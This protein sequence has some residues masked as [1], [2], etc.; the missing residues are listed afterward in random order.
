MTDDIYYEIPTK[1]GINADEIIR[2]YSKSNWG[3]YASFNA[4]ELPDEYLKADSF[5]EWLSNK[6]EMQLILFYYPPYYV[7][8]WHLDLR[9]GSTLNL[10]LT[11]DGNSHCIF[12]N[13]LNHTKKV[14]NFRELVYK[15]NTYYL[16]NTQVFHS[17]Y[18]FDK[19][20]YLIG[21]E[22]KEKKDTLSYEKLKNS[23]IEYYA[24]NQKS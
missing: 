7:Y 14:F 17:A 20:R 9:R 5:I 24:N 19:P 10:L 21:C 4:L 8:N 6:Y 22:F 3:E 15:P 12:T 18:N 23:V 16:L 13:Q 2:K 11:F 1:S